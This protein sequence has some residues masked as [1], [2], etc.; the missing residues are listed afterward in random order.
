MGQA[1]VVSPTSIEGSFFLVDLFFNTKELII[2][3][4]NIIWDFAATRHSLLVLITYV[5]QIV[6]CDDEI[7]KYR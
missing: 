2:S 4:R 3:I 6:W 1:N 5:S 7:E